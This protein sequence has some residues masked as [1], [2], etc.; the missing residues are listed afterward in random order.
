MDGRVYTAE[1]RALRRLHPARPEVTGIGPTFVNLEWSMPEGPGST[2]GF[3]VSA[4]AGGIWE[5]IIQDTHRP[6]GYCHLEPLL[7]DTWY[8]FRVAPVSEHGGVGWGSAPSKPCRTLRSDKRPVEL[9]PKIKR[10]AAA[11]EFT[12]QGAAAALV[13]AR[14]METTPPPSEEESIYVATATT[15]ALEAATLRIDLVEWNEEFQLA[16]GRPATA[17]ERQASP[18]RVDTLMRYQAIRNDRQRLR[19]EARMPGF[20]REDDL[21]DL[22]DLAPDFALAAS[23][24]FD[25]RPGTRHQT[26]FNE[27]RRLASRVSAKAKAAYTELLTSRC[28]SLQAF[29]ALST[30]NSDQLDVAIGLF[31]RFDADVDGVLDCSEFEALYKYAGKRAGGAS[32]SVGGGDFQIAFRRADVTASGHVD[33]NALVQYLAKSNAFEGL[34]GHAPQGE[35][36]RA[37]GGG[38]GSSD[39]TIDGRVASASP[40]LNSALRTS[41]DSAVL[42]DTEYLGRLVEQAQSVGRAGFELECMEDHRLLLRAVRAFRQQDHQRRG[43]LGKSDFVALIAPK[44]EHALARAKKREERQEEA[45]RQDKK[46][47]ASLREGVT[48]LGSRYMRLGHAERSKGQQPAASSAPSSGEEPRPAPRIGNA[49]MGLMGTGNFKQGPLRV[50]EAAEPIPCAVLRAANEPC[51][52]SIEDCRQ[53][54]VV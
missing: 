53:W 34:T 4:L 26:I 11:P 42:A 8:Q 7:P 6:S 32:G 13:V 17:S 2:S 1:Q 22:D 50:R 43:T 52:F 30:I 5:V 39:V 18:R 14:G 36:A 29:D 37:P 10:H 33:L 24:A 51:G 41:D 46:R 15:H 49:L 19:D 44:L 28:S 25:R 48:S 12:G 54:F 23:T 20:A 31:A 3:C 16:H 45:A 38:E 40:G 9:R 21:D 35:D 47:R 27:Q